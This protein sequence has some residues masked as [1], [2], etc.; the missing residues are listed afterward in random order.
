LE[1]TT[2]ITTLLTPHL[3]PHAAAFA[4]KVHAPLGRPA[5]AK[6]TLTLRFQGNDDVIRPED[7]SPV[8]NNLTRETVE[9]S[10]LLSDNNP[11]WN[12]NFYTREELRQM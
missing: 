4:P 3:K 9:N 6:D 7:S 5:L 1:K 2:L 12:G 8:G 11:A 10:A